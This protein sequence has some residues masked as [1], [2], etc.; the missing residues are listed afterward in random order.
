[1]QKRKGIYTQERDLLFKLAE[2]RAEG[3]RL[4]EYCRAVREDTK[5]KIIFSWN[6]SFDYDYEDFPKEVARCL[7]Y[8]QMMQYANPEIFP[9]F[10]A[11][12]KSG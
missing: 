1:M 4:P 9:T 6:L 7:Q 3:K 5:G 12:S 2:E 10:D 8:I 11:F